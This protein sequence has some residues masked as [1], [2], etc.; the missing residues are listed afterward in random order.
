MKLGIMQPYFFPYIGYFALIANTDKWVVFDITQYTKKS[1]LTRN[2][3]L[4]P[5]ESWQYVSIPVENASL[6]IKISEAKV[7]DK[8]KTKNKILGQ[9]EHYHK[10]A[11]YFKQVKDLINKTFADTKTDSLVELN[12]NSMKN[13]CEYLG[14]DF[15]YSIASEMGLKFPDK[16]DAGDWAFEISRQ[17]G[18]QEYI[19]PVGGEALFDKERFANAGIKLTILPPPKLEYD[20]KEYKF[21]PYLSMIDVLMWNDPVKV[22]QALISL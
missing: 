11:P 1:W 17:L 21:E 20:V 6:S 8:D 12:I 18:A 22:K 14:I 3:I 2:R 7:K 4:H 19:N 5:T 13:V 9:I 10:Q 16:M 15:N